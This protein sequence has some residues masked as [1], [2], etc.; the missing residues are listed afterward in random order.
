MDGSIMVGSFVFEVNWDC[1][2][3]GLQ[4]VVTEGL[5]NG[6]KFRLKFIVSDDLGAAIIG[7]QGSTKGEIQVLTFEAPHVC[8]IFQRGLSCS[9][10]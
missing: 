5:E 9:H 3:C 4:G 10:W 8:L 7:T 2:A 6:R 1:D